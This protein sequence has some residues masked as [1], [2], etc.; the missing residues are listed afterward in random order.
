[1]SVEMRCF[2]MWRR[3]TLHSIRM[4]LLR[5]ARSSFR[6]SALKT[7]HAQPSQD[8]CAAVGSESELRFRKAG[9]GETHSSVLSADAEGLRLHCR[10]RSPSLEDAEAVVRRPEC[11]DCESVIDHV[12]ML[13]RETPRRGALRTPS[14]LPAP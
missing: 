1:M 5:K 13:K 6:L 3:A 12:M 7:E 4:R 2:R 14:T 8:G 10:Y 11:P 9:P